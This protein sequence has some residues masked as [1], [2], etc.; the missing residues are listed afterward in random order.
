MAQALARLQREDPESLNEEDGNKE[1]ITRII[2]QINRLNNL[3]TDF[4][5]YASPNKP[6]KIIVTGT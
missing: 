2:R 1:Y 6:Q 5:S 3:L 4:F